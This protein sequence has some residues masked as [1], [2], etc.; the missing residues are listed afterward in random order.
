MERQLERS[1]S[2]NWVQ[3][4]FP[5]PVRRLFR[6]MNY[7]FSEH[8]TLIHRMA[9]TLPEEKREAVN[10]HGKDLC[11]ARSKKN[12]P[13]G[14]RNV[15]ASLIVGQGMWYF[16]CRYL[17]QMEFFRDSS[18]GW[19]FWGGS[20]KL[21]LASDQHLYDTGGHNAAMMARIAGAIP[22]TAFFGSLLLAAELT[23]DY[24]RSYGIE[25]WTQKRTGLVCDGAAR[26]YGQ[27]RPFFVR[28]S[29]IETYQKIISYMVRPWTIGT[30]DQI[31]SS[32]FG[33][34]GSTWRTGPQVLLLLTVGRAL[35]WLLGKLSKLT[36]LRKTA[37]KIVNGAAERERRH[38]EAIRD[39]A[40]E[41]RFMALRLQLAAE[42]R[43][44][45]KWN[46]F[47]PALSAEKAEQAADVV[48]RHAALD[49]NGPR[50]EYAAG[51]DACARD[52]EAIYGR[53]KLH[54]YSDS[55]RRLRELASAESPGG[56]GALD[57]HAE[58]LGRVVSEL[59]SE[60]ELS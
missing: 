30:P 12:F 2:R 32:T 26:A 15:M 55:Y 48:L 58:V 24:I 41:R 33:A 40:G 27:V 22:R 3:K 42:S 9:K 34:I 20:D 45:M 29:T 60:R 31:Y 21:F 54:K 6:W 11:T 1:K 19:L 47:R 14:V 46:P 5:K 43:T 49:A 38:F 4:T 18:L 52:L 59:Q 56:K 35:D 44:M 57:E 50:E 23:T 53:K 36:G 10:E 25:Y 13:R 7:H 17:E 51:L 39:L 37:E 28:Y 16:G 8:G